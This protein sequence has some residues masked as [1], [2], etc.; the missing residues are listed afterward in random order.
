M[1]WM[2]ATSARLRPNHRSGLHMRSSACF[3]ALASSAS[4]SLPAFM[5]LDC[6]TMSSAVSNVA[7][8]RVLVSRSL[9]ARSPSYAA[10]AFSGRSRKISIWANL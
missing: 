9:I 3:F 8:R 7:C 6:F 4:R 5:P 1:T 2:W 10:S